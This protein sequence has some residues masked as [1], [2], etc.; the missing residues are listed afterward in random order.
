MAIKATRLPTL[1]EFQEILDYMTQSWVFISDD[2]MYELKEEECPNETKSI[3]KTLSSI[4]GT[5]VE[6]S[7]YA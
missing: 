2:D 7:R 5:P 6:V 3:E 1:Q 4:A